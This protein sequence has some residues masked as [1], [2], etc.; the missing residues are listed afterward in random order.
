MRLAIDFRQRFDRDVV[1]DMYCYRR[2]GHNEGDEPRFTQPVMYRAI[3]KKPTVRAGLR[4]A[5]R[6]SEASVVSAERGDAHGARYSARLEEALDASAAPAT[7]PAPSAMAGFWTH[8]AAAR[9]RAA[10]RSPTAR[11]RREARA[12]VG[13]RSSTSPRASASHPKLA[14][15]LEARA[16]DGRRPAGRSTGARR[17]C[18]PRHA[19]AG[20]HARAAQRAGRAPRHVQPPPRGLFDHETGVPYTPLA[21]LR[22]ARGRSRSATARSPRRRARV[23][24]RLQPR[25]ARRAR[26]CGRRSSATS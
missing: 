15:V 1:I 8:Y 9:T 23:R 18:S 7:S 21:H 5:A 11:R 17:R 10:P 4:R 25:Y 13:E 12:R 2:H 22:A 3:D 14:K 20:G 19:R 16:A 26:R 6:R 24:V